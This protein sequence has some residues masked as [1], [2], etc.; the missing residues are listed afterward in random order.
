M[1]HLLT[2][3]NVK[4]EIAKSIKSGTAGEGGLTPLMNAARYNDGPEVIEV[5]LDAGADGKLKSNEGK[6]AFDYAEE[7]PRVKD[8]EAYS[9]LKKACN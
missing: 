2:L 7:N 6:T 5:L 3:E 8:S 4:A 1:L 9:L